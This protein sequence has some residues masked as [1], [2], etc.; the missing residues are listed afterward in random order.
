MLI[1]QYYEMLKIR[2]DRYDFCIDSSAV[3]S[4]YGL[5]DCRDLDFLHVNNIESLSP[6]IECHNHESHYYR[7]D[8]NDIIYNPTLHFYLH[9]I[10][11][12]NLQVVKDMKV[13]R[14]EEK[15]KRDVKL[16]N[17]VIQ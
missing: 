13:F 15:D 3:L 12:T 5:R 17:G 6:D 1:F 11:F 2:R 8:K 9:G 10:K 7:V 16:I 14:N 4:A